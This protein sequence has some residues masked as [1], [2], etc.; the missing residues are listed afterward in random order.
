MINKVTEFGGPSVT[1][2][3]YDGEAGRLHF[4][5]FHFTREGAASVFISRCSVMGYTNEG[6]FSYNERQGFYRKAFS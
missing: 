5:R 1:L 4:R 2:Y 3:G 6:V